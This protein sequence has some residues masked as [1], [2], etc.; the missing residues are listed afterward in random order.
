MEPYNIAFI[1]IGGIAH[2]HAQVIQALSNTYP[3]LPPLR[4][5]AASSRTAEKRAQFAN[6]F[7]FSRSS[8][9]EDLLAFAD[10]NTLFILGPNSIHVPYLEA[11]LEAPSIKSIYIEKPLCSS[12]AETARLWSKLDQGK[13][14]KRIMVGFQNFYALPIHQALAMWQAGEFGQP[15]HFQARYLHSGYLD[16]AYRLRRQTR[17]QPSPADGATADLGSHALSL[18]VAFLG[19]ELAVKAAQA[20]GSFP[21][22]P[23]GSD[24]CLNALLID[25]TSGAA[26]T[27]TASR[28]SAG[29]GDQLEFEL[30]GEKGSLRYSLEEPTILRTTLEGKGMQTWDLLSRIGK[31]YPP[32][33]EAFP[34]QHWIALLE[35]HYRFFNPGKF[36]ILLPDLKHGLQVQDLV[37]QIAIL[38]NPAIA[39]QV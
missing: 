2:V 27:L 35:S 10:I 37:N 32:A 4:L 20:S 28:V 22:V 25:R 9:P 11:A 18:L 8:S 33:P 31:I 16:P 1:G 3:D 17:L 6:R 13:A 36:P 12:I 30:W 39:D 15:I 7:G 14:E 21:D 5:V 24:L 34:K 38:I 29:T 19:A 26:G 23:P